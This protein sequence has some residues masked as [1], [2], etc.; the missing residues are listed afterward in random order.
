MLIR[1][2]K[3]I[4]GKLLREFL[5]NDI[6]VSVR[7]LKHLKFTDGAITVNGSFVTVKYVLRE[8]DILYLAME[9]KTEDVSPYITPSDIPIEILYED[10]HITVVNKPP[11]MPAHPSLGHH[12][13]TVANALAARYSEKP[14]VFRPVNRLDRDTSGVMLTANTQLDA[15]KLYKAM[16]DGKIRKKYLALTDGSLEPIGR[17]EAYMKL[18]DGSI[19]KRCECDESEVGAKLAVTEWRVISS[20]GGYSAVE[21]TPLTGRTHQIR[22]CMASLGAAIIGDTMYGAESP[23]IARQSL[24]A[25]ALTFVHPTLGEMTVKA[26]L[27]KDMLAAAESLNLNIGE[28]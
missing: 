16:I 1:I 6:G 2:D 11:A 4:S 7:Q 18:V 28:F 22:V 19:I 15:Y 27:P 23:L 5:L 3:E 26:P 10:A 8:G 14:Y 21:V 24:H 17:R 25:A 20:C 9:D 12:D 13:D